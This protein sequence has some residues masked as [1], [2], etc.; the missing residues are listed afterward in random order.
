MATQ[1]KQ[2]EFK[3]PFSTLVSLVEQLELEDALTLRNRLDEILAQREDAL[4]L[5]NPQV[6]AEIHEALAE[7]KAGEY[8]T[9]PKLKKDLKAAG[10]TDV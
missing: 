8:V 10:E 9:L 4:M 1:D 7:Y 5:S 2:L 6:M 3:I